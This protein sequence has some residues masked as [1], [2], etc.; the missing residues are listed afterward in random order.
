MSRV[1]VIIPTYNSA[2]YLGET[3]ESIFNQTF[4]DCEIIVVD[5]G[6]TDDTKDLL[7]PLKGK[8]NYIYQANSGSPA[9]PRNV[10]ISKASGDYI[11]IFDSDDIMEPEKIERS[12][13]FFESYPGLGMVFNNFIQFDD[14]CRYP[15]IHLDSYEHFRNMKKT[16]V[17]DHAYVIPKIEAFEG[18]FYENFIG[19]SGVVVPKKVFDKI[20]L[21]DEEVSA[22][23]LE[24]RDMWFR[25]TRCYEIGFL[26]IVG[27]RYRVR[28]N[29]VS[30]RVVLS[31]EARI[32]VIKRYME[33]LHCV[34]TKRQA[35]KLIAD[36]RSSVGYHYQ[37]TGDFGAARKSYLQS[38]KE[39]MNWPAL[40]GLFIT[41]LGR[42][43]VKLLMAVRERIKDSHA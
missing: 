38:L 5:D 23:G 41:I 25:I 29:S 14:K 21:F 3:L 34:K 36:C 20:G 8:I 28:S 9:K 26:N 15:G 27:H 16:K 40:W 30:K 35:R 13:A 4:M 2:R 12:V 6:S 7:Q 43:T 22:G 24:D 39:I 33:G 17:G 10:G 18:L 19:T 32:T 11:S 37:S 1:S 42:R 31:N